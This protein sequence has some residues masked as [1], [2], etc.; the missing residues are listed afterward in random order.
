MCAAPA[1]FLTLNDVGGRG[2]PIHVVRVPQDGLEPPQEAL[3]ASFFTVLVV[4]GGRG[5]AQHLEPL[6]LQA[7]DVHLIPPG[8]PHQLLSQADLHGVILGFDPKLLQVFEAPLELGEGAVEVMEVFPSQSLFLRGF[9]RLRPGAVRWERL[10]TLVT[11]LEAEL[12]SRAWGAARAA[13]ALL[14]LFLTELFRELTEHIPHPPAS[15]G[16]VVFEALN[17]IE[18]HCLEPLSLRDVA[19]AVQRTP[20]HLANAMREQTGLTV[21]DWV[22]EHRMVA[23]RRLLSE[24]YSVEET[25]VRAGYADVTHFIRTFR[26]V[27]GLTPRV[28]R[29][30]HQQLKTE[31]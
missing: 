2:K 9:L 23:A 17:F 25:A 21:G 24:G 30:Q 3:M 28:W 19:A 31:S 27:H 18:Q 13:Q 1:Q 16:G 6:D 11:E 5:R 4:V 29:T 26:R 10:L 12:N 22:R 7:G 15:A 20:S 8:I 14:T